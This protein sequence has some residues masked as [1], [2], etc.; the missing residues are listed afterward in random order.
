MEPNEDQNFHL[1][2]DEEE[3]LDP[4]VCDACLEANLTEPGNIQKCVVCNETYCIHSTSAIDAAHCKECLSDLT[5]E[6]IVITRTEYS[7]KNKSVRSRKARQ[8]TLGGLHWLFT[9]RKI[10]ML[11]DDELGAAIE[12]HYATHNLLIAERE[13]RRNKV[14]HRNAG[15]KFIKPQSAAS[16]NPSFVK[17]PRQPKVALDPIAAQLKAMADMLKKHGLSPEQIA[18]TMATM[19]S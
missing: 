14:A 2:P 18:V 16:A 6:D 11:N 13:A 4:L 7:E 8:I 5:V 17:T 15:I 10:P 3:L 1:H 19:K 9:Q 12:Y